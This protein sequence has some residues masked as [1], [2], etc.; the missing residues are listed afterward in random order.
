MQTLLAALLFI[1]GAP[2]L[3]GSTS[4]FGAPEV[5]YDLDQFGPKL[6]VISVR[7]DKGAISAASSPDGTL[8]KLHRSGGVFVD[9]SPLAFDSSG[10]VRAVNQLRGDSGVDLAVSF[11]SPVA[12]EGR[13]SEDGVRYVFVA[14][15]NNEKMPTVPVTVRNV[16]P[17]GDKE[18]ELRGLVRDLTL[19]VL[20]LKK[21]LL[22]RDAELAKLKN[23]GKE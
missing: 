16:E 20:S 5:G 8:F 15:Q 18:N 4:A 14:L 12:V 21:E 1:F 6:A 11:K 2:A 9:E 13:E 3:F 7:A 17:S 10:I 19:E 23:T 22:Q